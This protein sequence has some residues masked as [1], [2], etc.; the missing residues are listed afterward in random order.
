M[1]SALKADQIDS[2]VTLIND[3]DQDDRL[4]SASTPAAAAVEVVGP[5]PRLQV[6]RRAAADAAHSLV[7]KDLVRDLPTG[8]YIDLTMVFERN[9]TR[10][11][12]VPVQVSAGGVEREE[13]GYK[14]AETDSAGKPIVEEEEAA[15]E[16]ASDPRGDQGGSG[17]A[18]E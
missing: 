1:T 13:H 9:G 6:P 8:S 5:T 15:P 11:L 14:I 12:L 4:L 18:G 7:L 10:T 3:S 16:T 2:I 17:S